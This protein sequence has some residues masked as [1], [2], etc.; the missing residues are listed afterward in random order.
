MSFFAWKWKNCALF[1][2]RRCWPFLLKIACY[3]F[4]QCFWVFIEKRQNLRKYNH[5]CFIK[6]GV[7][8]SPRSM[9]VV[10]VRKLH[11][12]YRVNIYLRFV[13]PGLIIKRFILK[14]VLIRCMLIYSKSKNAKKN[15]RQYC[16]QILSAKEFIGK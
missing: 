13:T 7:T 16:C 12:C 1:S 14:D 15:Y 3:V 11:P 9:F 2:L 6:K 10:S 4:Q 5:A 8:R